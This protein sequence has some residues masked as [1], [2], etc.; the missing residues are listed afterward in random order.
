[1]RRSNRLRQ[2][3]ASQRVTVAMKSLDDLPEEII[4][5]IGGLLPD[6]DLVSFSHANL[7]TFK[8][9]SNA[10]LIWKRSLDPDD[11]KYCDKMRQEAQEDPDPVQACPEKEMFFRRSKTERNWRQNNFK[12]IDVHDIS[13]E[14]C[15]CSVL[16]NTASYKDFYVHIWFNEGPQHWNL[17][18]IDMSRKGGIQ[19]GT[20]QRNK[21]ADRSHLQVFA[22]SKSIIIVLE[23]SGLLPQGRSL[24]AIDLTRADNLRVLWEHNTVEFG[25]CLVN[26]AN[27]NIYK[28]ETDLDGSTVFSILSPETGI[29]ISTWPRDLIE[30]VRV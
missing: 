25:M 11:R 27:F 13:F 12:I 17:T 20:L 2:K 28:W 15:P 14:Q 4:M 22:A 19:T 5:K 26:V 9:F 1:M 30:K 3:R 24:F 8:M 6:V 21:L 7:R 10:S 16:E 23:F 18:W 29:T